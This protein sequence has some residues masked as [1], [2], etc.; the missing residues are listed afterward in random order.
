MTTSAL[1]AQP[2]D[3]NSDS[4]LITNNRSHKLIDNCHQIDFK[5]GFTSYNVREMLSTINSNNNNNRSD[6]KSH[7]TKVSSD[8]MATQLKSND[9]KVN[10]LS[11]ESPSLLKPNA[12]KNDK[13]KECIQQTVRYLLI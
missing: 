9:S 4:L 5:S 13:I 7:S 3:L 8:L 10:E 11:A 2:L 1:S 12:N 6:G